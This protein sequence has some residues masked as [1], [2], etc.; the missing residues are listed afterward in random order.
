MASPISFKIQHQSKDSLARTG[1]LKTHHGEVKTPMFMP[2]GTL[3]TV[4]SLSPEEITEIGS[5]VILSNTYHLALRPGTDII[6]L[7]GGIHR[8]M[9][10][11]GPILTDSGGFQ[12][13]SLAK[14]RVITEEGVTFRNHLNGDL[15]SLT[16]EIAIT[17]QKEIGADIIMAFD[18]CIPFPTDYAYAKLS[19]ERTLR[20]AAR[21]IASP[22]GSHQALFGIVQGGE[23]AD[24]REFSAKGT[25]ALPFDGFAIGGTSIG[26]PKPVFSSML[27]AAIPHL[28][29]EKPRYVMGIGSLDYILE[30]I[31]QGVDMFDCVL[32]TRLA[33]HGALMTTQG[34][35]NIKD[36]EYEKDFSPID[37]S[38]DCSTC[39][40][41]T[42][43]YLRHLF[44]SDE[45]LGKRLMSI[46]NLR[47]LIKMVEGARLAIEED[48]FQDYAQKVLE[49]YGDGRGF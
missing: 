14:N 35:I 2:V 17:K 27:N 49:S 40:R 36:G 30:A 6:Q 45:L 38:C 48:R 19:T 21:C 37:S 13:F 47:F 20:W 31:G 9:Q 26:E 23:F 44:R 46:H 1:M 29:L 33:R 12:V 11:S 24:L 43:A 16:P 10:Y 8:F 42:R 22:R 32:P 34:R 3:A 7:A 28:P 39:K 4:K 41:Y 15:M 25:T 5:G 18:E